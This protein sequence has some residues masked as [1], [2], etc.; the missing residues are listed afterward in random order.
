MCPFCRKSD[1]IAKKGTYRKRSTRAAKVQ[2]FLC[3]RCRKSYSTQTGRMSYREKKP[4]VN[5]LIYRFLC[6]GVSQARIAANLGLTRVT[7][8]RKII[9]LARYARRDHLQWQLNQSPSIEVQ[10]DEMET[11][12]HTKCKPISIGLAINKADRSIISAIAATM[13]AKG[14]LAAISRKKYGRR[15]DR[16]GLAMKLLMEQIKTTYGGAIVTVRT[17]K[18]TSYGPLVREYLPWSLHRTTK[19]RRGCV[20]GQGELKEGG[21][22][23]IF[24]LNHN[25]AMIRDNL[26][27][28]SRRVWCTVKSM[29]RFQDLLDLYVHFHNRL[30]DPKDPLTVYL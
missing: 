28:M 3:K 13:P 8:A 19:G 9:K 5:Q 1:R 6:S 27:T 11:F 18:K 7:V 29:C 26:K 21:Y 2:R 4:H 24:N 17:D 15:P 10:F 12:E 23:P 22:D 20:V 30:C 16:R 25:A 14:H